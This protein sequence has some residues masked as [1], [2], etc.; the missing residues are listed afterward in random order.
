MIQ[1]KEQ[2]TRIEDLLP[3]KI[4]SQQS[5]S[6]VQEKEKSG[7]SKTNNKEMLQKVIPRGRP[8]SGR[9]WKEP[10]Q[11]FSS[12]VKTKGI[13]LSFEKKQKLREELKKVK[14]LSREIKAQ[15][16]AEK[17]AKKERRRENLKRTEEKQ[18][19]S[20]VIQVIKNTA[21]IKRMKKKQLRMIEKR[22]TV[23]NA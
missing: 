7:D 11:K 12:I 14:E 19:K 15:K 1:T 18:K 22:D 6:N 16:E 5:E 2:V 17:Q 23:K 4:E 8:K 21:K 3:D 13:R 20:E 10:K 9:I